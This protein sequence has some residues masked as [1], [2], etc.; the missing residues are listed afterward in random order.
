MMWN[1]FKRELT[2]FS[3]IL[4]YNCTILCNLYWFTCWNHPSVHSINDLLQLPFYQLIYCF[5]NRMKF[6]R[7]TRMNCI[8]YVF[9]F[10]IPSDLLRQS[11]LFKNW[12]HSFEVSLGYESVDRSTFSMKCSSASC[13]KC[14]SINARK[15]QLYSI[16]VWFKYN[17]KN[18]MHSF[19]VSLGNESVDRTTFST[20]STTALHWKCTSVNAFIPQWNNFNEKRKWCNYIYI[21]SQ[22]VVASFLDY[23][24][25]MS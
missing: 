9:M 18:W 13:W 23:I 4:F 6:I 12:M 1:C 21:M 17:Y 15:I 7:E 5:Y 14:S 22:L 19:E 16:L 20:W 10:C 3:Y 25:M 11:Y 8:I 24:Y 2:H